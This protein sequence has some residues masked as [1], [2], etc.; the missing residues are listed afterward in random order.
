VMGAGRRRPRHLPTRR[1]SRK[2]DRCHHGQRI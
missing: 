1:W 2:T